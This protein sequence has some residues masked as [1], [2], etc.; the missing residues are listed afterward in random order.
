MLILSRKANESIMIGDSIEVTVL[1]TEGNSVKLGIKA[2]AD[3]KVLRRELWK[4]FLEQEEIARRL[5]AGEEPENFAQ[6]RE[7]LVEN[8]KAG[9]ESETI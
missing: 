3:I 4:A 9:L 8:Q 5:A 6:L 1:A 2:P 7:L